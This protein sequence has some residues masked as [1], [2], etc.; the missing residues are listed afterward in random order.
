M[1]KINCVICH[2]GIG[3]GQGELLGMW[4]NSDCNFCSIPSLY[5]LRANECGYFNPY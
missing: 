2:G 5:F 4:N 3:N 1:Y